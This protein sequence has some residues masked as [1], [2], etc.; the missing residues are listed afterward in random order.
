MIIAPLENISSQALY[1]HRSPL[2]RWLGDAVII[3]PLENISSQALYCHRSPLSRW[4]GDGVII[5]PLENILSQALYCRRS[6]PCRLTVHLGLDTAPMLEELCDSIGLVRVYMCIF[7][8]SSYVAASPS[9]HAKQTLSCLLHFLC[10]LAI[11]I[12]C[13]FPFLICLSHLLF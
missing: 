9:H 7:K 12:T 5:A 6:P 1:C 13:I 11:P 10:L 2:S 3:A 8:W 4:L